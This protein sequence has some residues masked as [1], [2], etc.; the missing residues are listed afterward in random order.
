MNL[1]YQLNHEHN[2]SSKRRFNLKGGMYQL[3]WNIE[4][5]YTLQTVLIKMD[6]PMIFHY[7]QH[8]VNS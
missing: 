8:K 2:D 4:T 5:T 1:I 6:V 7:G 3:L